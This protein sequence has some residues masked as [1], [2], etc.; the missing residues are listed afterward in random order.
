MGLATSGVNPSRI[1][2]RSFD[3]SLWSHYLPHLDNRS[4]A[5]AATNGKAGAKRGN[6]K[7]NKGPQGDL[8]KDL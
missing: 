3:T 5:V 8:L 1:L 4:A 7:R 2:M 6:E